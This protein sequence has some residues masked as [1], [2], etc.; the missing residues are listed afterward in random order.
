MSGIILSWYSGYK[1]E[2]YPC[3]F[4]YNGLEKEVDKLI[5]SKLIESSETKKRKRVF[6]VETEDSEVY[7]LTVGEKTK[8]KRVV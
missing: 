5:E 4:L 2:E 7:M 6:L 1:G 3:S 8:I